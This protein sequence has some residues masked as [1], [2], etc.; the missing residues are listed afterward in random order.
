MTIKGRQG[1]QDAIK[2]MYEERNAFLLL[3]KSWQGL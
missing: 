1:T 2:G 3:L